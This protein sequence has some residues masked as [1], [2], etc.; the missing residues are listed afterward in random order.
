MK[1]ILL[2]F[3]LLPQLLFAQKVV[4]LLVVQPP[5][6]GFSV[7]KT[8][9]TIVKGR[10]VILGTDLIVFGGSGDYLY[11]WSP[12]TTLNNA[13]V[14]NPVATPTDTTTY[15]LTVADENGCS[16]SIDYKVNV[17]NPMVGIQDVDIQRGLEAVLFPNPNNGKFKVK[18]TGNPTDEIVLT[19]VD[20]G[21]R[22]VKNQTILNFNGEHT[23]TVQV[24]LVSGIYTLKIESDT[25]A[26]SRQFIIN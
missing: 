9:T 14:L 4:K 12:Q 26:M 11:S 19:I 16:F 5:E 13:T 15:I 22:I 24:S 17:R 18:L 6:F 21:G 23:E 1:K 2:L 25:G 7:S 20:A 10:T 8:D 3:F